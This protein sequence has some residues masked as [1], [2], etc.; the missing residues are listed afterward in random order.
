MET[1][2]N[3]AEIVINISAKNI[4]STYHYLIPPHLSGKVLIGSC[5]LVPFGRQTQVGFV[6]GY[7]NCPEEV[8][9]K[10]I[11][12]IIGD[13]PLFNK[14]MLKIA[15]WMSE[16]YLCNLH[17][18][19]DLILPVGKNLKTKKGKLIIPQRR[20]KH[21]EYKYE[22]ECSL[23]EITLSV[24]QKDA[25][26]KIIHLEGRA[27]VV[28]LMG[29]TGSGKTEVYTRVI[30]HFVKKG[31][32]AIVLVP[33]ISLTPQIEERFAVHFKDR[34]AV[35][36]SKI[37]FGAKLDI[38]QKIQKGEVDVVIGARSTIFTPIDNLG[39]IVIDEEQDTS[40]KQENTPKYNARDIA[41]I[42]AKLNDAILI[43]GSAT[44][45]LETYSLSKKGVYE[46][47]KLTKRID[48]VPL[49]EVEVVDMRPEFKKKREVLSER[50]ISEIKQ[51]LLFSQ[52]I[53][54]FL[55][56]RGFSTAIW[57]RSCGFIYLCERCSVCLTYHKIENKLRCHWC[58]Y[59]ENVPYVCKKCESASISFRGLGIQQVEEM[60]K[61]TFEGVRVLRMDR[62]TTRG[63]Y[64]H[65]EIISKFERKEADIL[66]GTQMITKGLDFPGVS[67]VG[68]INADIGF[69]IPD[70][71]AG[72]RLF[73]ILVQVAGRA[74]RRQVPGKVIVQTHLPQHYCIR[75]ALSHKVE[76]FF[77]EELKYRRE[78]F[79]PPY[80]NLINL[81][82]VGEDEGKIIS[83]SEKIS[84]MLKGELL[85]NSKI[86]YEIL[87]CTPSVIPRVKNRFRYNLLVKCK[88]KNEMLKIINL[89]LSKLKKAER[90][91]VFPDVDPQN[92][93]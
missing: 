24:E 90:D 3:I 63:K 43:L 8:K 38:Y 16:Y 36:H 31:K 6:I 75:A 92:L 62:D 7:K 83:T 33:E 64:S 34:M 66:L 17:S 93:I 23:P 86:K 47:V 25:V 18:A 10:E 85:N 78:L 42:R 68:V 41:K 70:F 26:E 39:V 69:H 13:A 20:E 1:D 59:E 77:C 27:R 5:V 11:I 9:L 49:P 56:R 74:G 29:V 88:P 54:L 53:L 57:C 14:E 67:L 89:S 12:K 35:L 46:F 55:N 19:I 84:T 4:T 48:D 91:I 61:K 52:Q 51:C 40:Y 37:P 30:S 87:P 79:Y 58:G 65:Y 50:L 44:P 45:S 73:Q 28:L 72:E 15:R 81:Q 32:K 60:I 2:K 80:S 21:K 71:R 76:D 22:K 82:F